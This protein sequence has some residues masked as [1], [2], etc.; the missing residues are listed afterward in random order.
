MKTRTSFCVLL[1]MLLWSCTP[2]SIIPVGKYFLMYDEYIDREA[3][4]CEVVDPMENMEW[5]HNKM[6]AFK[7][8]INHVA[9]I[10]VT[11]VWMTYFVVELYTY[12][13]ESETINLLYVSIDTGETHVTEGVYYDCDGRVTNWDFE[14]GEGVLTDKQRVCQILCT[15]RGLI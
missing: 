2:K 1:V 9:S 4:C 6:I 5:L 3:V 12:E 15:Y 8:S 10:D 14:L 7:D 11:Q 13:N